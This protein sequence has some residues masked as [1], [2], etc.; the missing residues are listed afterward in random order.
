MKALII[1]LLLALSACQSMPDRV[2]SDRRDALLRHERMSDFMRKPP[3]YD[4]WRHS[5]VPYG[6][7]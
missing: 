7:R 1:I 6:S 3:F 4:T 5:G 2:S